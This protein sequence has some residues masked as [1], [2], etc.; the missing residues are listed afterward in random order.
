MRIVNYISAMIFLLIGL[1]I[2]NISCDKAE[3]MPE[4]SD[5]PVEEQEIS[6][7]DRLVGTWVRDYNSLPTYDTLLISSDGTCSYIKG[8]SDSDGLSYTTTC[9]F[10]TSEQ[11][12][13]LYNS[14]S[15]FNPY[16]HYIKFY[17]DFSYFVM[18]NYPFDMI[19][20]VINVGFRK[21]D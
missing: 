6:V 9:F 18:Y 10:E 13:V 12:I 19:D 4:F 14:L 15:D 5:T 7:A 11:F 2:F 20:M 17:D 1:L 8:G 16:P 21:I 3:P